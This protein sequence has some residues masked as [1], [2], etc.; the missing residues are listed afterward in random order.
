MDDFEDHPV[1][2]L[3]S[4][5]ESKLALFEVQ[6]KGGLAY[7][8]KSCEARFRKAPEA[9]DSVDM[10]FTPGKF[11]TAMI[12]PKVFAIADIDKAIVT[13][14]AIGIDDA[15]GFDLAANKGL[16]RGF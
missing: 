7:P 2:V 5:V 13:T 16:Q 12:N 15:F 9:F 8:S 6:V 3:V 1:H 4:I 11:V 14:P 10:S